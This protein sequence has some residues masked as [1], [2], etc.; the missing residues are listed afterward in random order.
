MLMRTHDRAVEYRYFF[1]GLLIECLHD[2][3]PDTQT[4]PIGKAFEY[5][6][7]RTKLGWKIAPRATGSQNVK[8][9]MNESPRIFGRT[10]HFTFFGWKEMTN[11][12]ILL[13]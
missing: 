3:G 2:T 1:V 6:I 5:G 7:P 4:T 8:N 9:S 11:P 12:L 13:F 10:T